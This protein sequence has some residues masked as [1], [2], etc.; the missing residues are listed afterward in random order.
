M[1]LAGS[2]HWALFQAIS[3]LFTSDIPWS[4]AGRSDAETTAV[5]EAG[6]L[7]RAHISEIPFH[8]PQDAAF[9]DH[10]LSDFTTALESLLLALEALVQPSVLDDA[11][12]LG[13]RAVLLKATR[14]FAEGSL[15]DAFFHLK[16]SPNPATGG[17][18]TEMDLLLALCPKG[19][20]WQEIRFTVPNHTGSIPAA[21]AESHER[22]IEDVCQV[23]R[24]AYECQQAVSIYVHDNKLHDTSDFDEEPSNPEAEH[25]ISLS[26][27]LD[28]QVLRDRFKFPLVHKRILALT[29]A[30]S[31]L[32]LYEGPWIQTDWS[33]EHVLFAYG[34]DRKRVYDI[35]QP[36]LPCTLSSEHEY[37]STVSDPLHNN[38]LILSFGRLLM[39]MDKGERIAIT[40]TVRSKPSLYRTLVAELDD[41]GKELLTSYYTQAV[42]GCLKFPKW[43]QANR[44]MSREL[45]YRKAILE[46]ILHPLE[47]EV[48]TFPNQGADTGLDDGDIRIR[49]LKRGIRD[50]CRKR[51]NISYRDPVREKRNFVA[52]SPEH[53]ED[54]HGTHVIGLL[55]TLAPEAD[56]YVGKITRGK[57]CE[58]QD[59]G[60]AAVSILHWIL[61]RGYASNDVLIVLSYKALRW[62]VD[63]V[64]ADIISMSFGFEDD[65]GW[66]D[67]MDEAIKHSFTAG[68]IAF[69]AASNY[70]GNSCRTYPAKAGT[71]F[72][73]H[74]SDG[75]GNPS[76]LDP[77]PIRGDYNFSTLGVAVPCGHTGDREIFKTGTS[78]AT[79]VAAG[80]AANIIDLADWLAAAGELTSAQKKKLR[81]YEGM[82]NIF[83]LM[84]P[85]RR[86]DY[87]YVA[88]WNLWNGKVEEKIIWGKIREKLS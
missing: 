78:Y 82:R 38:P 83:K 67:D 65:S 76:G 35:H 25:T 20:P 43:L 49:A 26:S 41:W 71:V 48:S 23:A 15:E 73:I 11:A 31:L 64:K 53:D 80:L 33:A 22:L 69:A 9:S 45:A 36:Y 6:A 58:N 54:G 52:G 50:G 29:L 5:Q 42:E 63:E 68:R 84:A 2:K 13:E 39:E 30:R 74:A 66:D 81:S 10:T 70:G 17:S 18:S 27:L 14:S 88:P 85:S 3:P 51:E 79:P 44:G 62:A 28:D 60:M 1:M 61:M 7:L 86:Q 21:M 37:Q 56:L 46:K 4:S 24:E 16:A 57:K 87:D 59:Q 19:N 40:K 8:V 32:N 72:C 75:H 12:A 55:L 47:L 34:T 77:T